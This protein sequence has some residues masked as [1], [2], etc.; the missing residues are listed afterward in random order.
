MSHSHTVKI[1]TKT[2]TTST[3]TEPPPPSPYTLQ[4]E[5]DGAVIDPRLVPQ[6]VATDTGDRL[7]TD[8]QAPVTLQQTTQANSVLT[9]ACERKPTPSGRPF[10]GATWSTFGTFAQKY[11]T[12]ETRLR[13]DEAN[14]TWPSW[15][16]LPQG[17]KAPFPEIDAVEAYGSMAC[18][19]PG[20]VEHVVYGAGGPPSLYAIVPLANSTGWH[21]YRFVWTATRIDFSI[22]GVATFSVTDPAKI[23]QVA[24][25]PI[26]TCGVG[27][28][29]CRVD[30][31]TVTPSRLL[32]EVDYLRI[33]A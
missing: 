26:F 6:Y 14:G 9:L 8:M 13:Y 31:P 28:P 11:G 32:M 18:L 25:Y 4:L 5:F 24:M 23:P 1:G 29:G 21:V 2:Y 22:D 20:Q 12:F 17:S 16:F 30:V 15:F 10:A 7:D 19:G 27:A 3:Y 33:S